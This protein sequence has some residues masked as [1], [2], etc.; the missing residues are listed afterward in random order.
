MPELSFEVADKLLTYDPNTG[1]LRWKATRQ[2]NA[3]AGAIAGS[4]DG[5]GYRHLTIARKFYRSHRVAWLL[6][7]GAWPDS[8]LLVDHINGDRLDNRICNLRLGTKSQNHGNRGPQKNNTSGYKGVSKGKNGWHAA[9]RLKGKTIH[10]GVYDDI[11]EARYVYARK[12][13][14]LFGEFARIE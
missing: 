7:Y 8:N 11:D 2:G 5:K 10:L 14:E 12:A 4:I 13:Y 9:I 3:K 6:Y 1:D